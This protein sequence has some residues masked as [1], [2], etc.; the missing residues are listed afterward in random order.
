MLLPI[1]PALDPISSWP[2][3]LPPSR[4][5]RVSP[6]TLKSFNFSVGHRSVPKAQSL[7]P[8]VTKQREIKAFLSLLAL[9]LTSNKFFYLQRLKDLKS[10]DRGLRTPGSHH[11]KK[12]L[13]NPRA[14]GHPPHPAGASTCLGSRRVGAGP[15]RSAT[16]TS[17]WGPRTKSH[18]PLGDCCNCE[19]TWSHTCSIS[20]STVGQGDARDSGVGPE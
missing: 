9:S 11:H 3:F 20:S 5:G 6:K 10:K 8:T 1:A 2:H 15:Y 7:Q 19:A 13:G 12:C 4:V 17:A 18:S 16:A 14:P